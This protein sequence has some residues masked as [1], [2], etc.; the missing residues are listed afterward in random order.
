MGL[1]GPKLEWEEPWSW[2]KVKCCAK[3]IRS[4]LPPVWRMLLYSAALPVIVLLVAFGYIRHVAPDEPMLER[5]NQLL[6][7]MPAGISLLVCGLP[8][9]YALCPMHVIIRRSSICFARANSASVIKVEL[10]TAIFFR[11]IDGRRHFVV[12]AKT[13]KGKPFKRTIEMPTQKVAEQEVF[14]FLCEAGLAH[15]Y[16][17]DEV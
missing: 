3:E 14:K 12:R 1:F 7:L 13:P 10:I 6:I 15:L 16:R 11:D 2:A 8:Y 17:S 9:L 5:A 4:A